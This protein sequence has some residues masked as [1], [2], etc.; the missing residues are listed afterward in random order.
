MDGTAH[1]VLNFVTRCREVVNFTSRPLYAPQTVDRKLMSHK[2][3]VNIGNRTV[4]VE[5]VTQ[6]PNFNEYTIYN[7]Q[8]T[9]YNIKYTIYNKQYTIHNIQYI[10]YNI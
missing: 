5:A 1:T 4:I 6:S 9:I 3:G 7:I 2:V 10:I 8:Y